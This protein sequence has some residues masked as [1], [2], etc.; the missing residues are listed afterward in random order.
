MI[1]GTLVHTLLCGRQVGTDEFGNRYYEARKNPRTGERR[2]RW[3]LFKG[4]IEASKVPPHWHAWLH[5]TTDAPIVV[6]T[7]AWEKPHTKNMTG[8]SSAYV[9]PGDDRAGGRRAPATGDYE[10]WRPA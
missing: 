5:Y 6:S 10:P 9:P 8:S 4:E 3:V 1:T 2:R 7:H